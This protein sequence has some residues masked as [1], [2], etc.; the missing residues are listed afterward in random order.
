MSWPQPNRGPCRERKGV[1]CVLMCV[2]VCVRATVCVCGER[3]RERWRLTS[4]LSSN[5]HHPQGENLALKDQNLNHHH[6]LQPF[7]YH[8]TYCHHHFLTPCYNNSIK[9]QNH[10]KC[11]LWHHQQSGAVGACWAHNPEVDGSKP[12]S[13]KNFFFF[14]SPYLFSLSSLFIFS[15]SDFCLGATMYNRKENK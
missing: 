15:F 4:A 6:H 12:S 11:Y 1:G 9:I 10:I 13:A 2:C 5:R 8:L 14:F 7:S 3:E